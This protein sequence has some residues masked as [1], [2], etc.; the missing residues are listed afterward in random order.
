MT[1]NRNHAVHAAMTEPE[2][3]MLNRLELT[4]VYA[5]LTYTAH[6]HNVSEPVIREVVTARFD[7]SDVT[8]LRRQS[9]GDAVEFL[10]DLQMDIPLN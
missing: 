9:Y 6:I 1:L 10:V 4:S 5:L 7:I 2:S 3:V 8:Q